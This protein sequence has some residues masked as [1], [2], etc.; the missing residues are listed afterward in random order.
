M[1][2]FQAL[3]QYPEYWES[4]E[5]VFSAFQAS[6]LWTHTMESALPP[7]DLLDWI[8]QIDNEKYCAEF[9]ESYLS[10]TTLSSESTAQETCSAA[11]G[12][13][14]DASSLVQTTENT[15]T[16]K[17]KSS[18]TVLDSSPPAKRSCRASGPSS[19][20][21]NAWDQGSNPLFTHRSERHS[22]AATPSPLTILG[23]LSS[24]SG[25]PA[26]ASTGS[27]STK[28]EQSS[29][30]SI[31]FQTSDDSSPS[32]ICPEPDTRVENSGAKKRKRSDAAVGSSS[33]AKM[34]RRSG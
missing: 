30:Q 19:S 12:Q 21:E 8:Q 9:L 2:E 11:Q 16:R 10:P 22:L 18:N 20:T 33:P 31:L 3:I 29:R 4:L 7:H 27:P 13:S 34:A 32:I 24:F 14:S 17:R 25:Q 15:G 6:S 28:Q 23:D 5:V 26:S 1:Q